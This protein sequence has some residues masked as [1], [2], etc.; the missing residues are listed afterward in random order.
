MGLILSMSGTFSSPT[1]VT[2]GTDLSGDKTVPLGGSCDFVT[3]AG[4]EVELGAQS[5]WPSITLYNSDG[6]GGYG[7]S[8]VQT[9]TGSILSAS[10]YALEGLCD[11]Q[12]TRT[13]GGIRLVGSSGYPFPPNYLLKVDV[14]AG[15]VRSYHTPACERYTYSEGKSAHVKP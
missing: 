9:W 3:T 1:T 12:L 6:M 2:M 14:T 4:D 7:P 5:L 11:N 13:W 10:D 8:G 15:C